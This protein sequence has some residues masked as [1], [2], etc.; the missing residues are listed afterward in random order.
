MVAKND[1][2][3]PAGFL[4]HAGNGMCDACYMRK[5]RGS[6]SRAFARGNVSFLRPDENDMVC[7]RPMSNPEWWFS[8]DAFVVARAKN[9]CQSCPV[10]AACREDDLSSNAR[11]HGVAG[12]L[13]KDERVR[14]RALRRKEAA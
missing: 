4:Q 14:L 5:R 3:R 2:Q 9:L 6:T 8:D 11:P 12:G 1:E 7:G 13:S 10:L